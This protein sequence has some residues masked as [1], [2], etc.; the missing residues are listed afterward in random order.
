MRGLPYARVA[1]MLPASMWGGVVVIGSFRE[2]SESRESL[3]RNIH[4]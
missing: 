2:L 4:G 1:K 3:L